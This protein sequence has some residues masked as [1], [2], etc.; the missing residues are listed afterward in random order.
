MRNPM[1]LTGRT[2]VVTGTGQG[3]GRAI[4]ELVLELGGNLV[5]VERNPETF[6]AVS[7]ALAGERTLAIQGDVTD[8]AVCARIVDDA[9]ARFGA[10]HGL[11][12]NAG[13]TRPAMIEK[14]T[15]PQWQAVIDV[16]LTACHLMQQAVGRHMIG[17]AKAGEATP[18]AIVNIS[19]TA[20]KRGSIGQVNYSAAKAG[21]YG[22]TMTAAREWARHGIRVNSVG[23]GTVE[24]PMTGLRKWK[25]AARTAPIRPTSLN[26]TQVASSPGTSV[27][28]AKARPSRGVQFTAQVSSAS[29]GMVSAADP[30]SIC[31]PTIISRLP[32][33]V[34]LRTLSV[35]T[36]SAATPSRHSI[37]PVPST[38]PDRRD[39]MMMA[40]PRKP[41]HN[42]ATPSGRTFSRKTIQPSRATISG[43]VASKGMPLAVA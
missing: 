21:L 39:P 2:I 30:T 43:I 22:I 41:A 36:A 16:N 40:A 19:S 35:A 11:V 31:K 25:V 20:G 12:N 9:V 7:A 37:T 34:A 24:T 1:E 17:R 26:Q 5:M 32:P 10:V 6:A 23:F 15:L 42:P 13:I 4:S 38:P 27:V 3:I 8:E 28:K 14:M 29:A 18:G 33:E